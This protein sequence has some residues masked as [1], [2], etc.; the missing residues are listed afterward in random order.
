MIKTRAG[1]EQTI[2]E[3]LL[4]IEIQMIMTKGKKQHSNTEM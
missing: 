3:I 2:R 1:I 4:T